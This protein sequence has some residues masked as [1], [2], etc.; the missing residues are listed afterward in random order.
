MSSTAVA[1]SLAT[2]MNDGLCTILVEEKALASTCPENISGE[3][4][5]QQS[6]W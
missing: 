4:G 3:K 5:K 2:L 6:W 1:V